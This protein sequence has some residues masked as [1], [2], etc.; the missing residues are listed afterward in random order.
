M[1][2]Y[3][4]PDVPGRLDFDRD[5]YRRIADATDRKRRVHDHVV[6]I[7]SGYAW[8]VQAGCEMTGGLSPP[9]FV[10]NC[11]RGTGSTHAAGPAKNQVTTATGKLDKLPIA[12][13]RYRVTMSR[14]PEYDAPSNEI[15]IGAGKDEHYGSVLHHVLDTSGYLATD[16][17]QHTMLG[18]DSPVSTRDRVVSN[19]AEGVEVAV[20]TEHNVVADF[21]PIVQE[22]GLGAWMVALPGDE[23]TS[24]ASKKPWGHANVFPLK[25]DPKD[26]RGGALPVRDRTARELF[27]RVPVGMHDALVPGKCGE[28]DEQG[29]A[30]QMKVGQECVDDGEAEPGRHEQVGCAGA[31]RHGA[32]AGGAFQ[33]AHH[34]RSCGNDPPAV[35]FGARHGQRRRC[36]GV[37]TLGMHATTVAP[38]HG[39]RSTRA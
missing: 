38:R 25:A 2:L 33:R 11:C 24:D 1:R 32:A 8:P 14:G 36:G 10:A 31:A 37:V 22:L 34:R 6:P 5:L 35:A 3:R 19:L 23:L 17:H 20:A 7:R 30:R 12:P 4:D 26:P 39:H 13:G 9:R 15:D 18:T 16:F 28:Q 21:E 27:D 29:R